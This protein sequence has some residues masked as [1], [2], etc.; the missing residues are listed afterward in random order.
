M[1]RI[2]VRYLPPLSELTSKSYEDLQ[3]EEG[4]T[5]S[6]LLDN[7]FRTYR[8][9]FEQNNINRSS[10]HIVIRLNNKTLLQQEMSARL[11]NDDS[12]TLWIP[13]AGG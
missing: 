4:R 7:L 8:K 5:V 12:I 3:V 9:E 6:E 13:L 10:P 2:F 1:M 11:H